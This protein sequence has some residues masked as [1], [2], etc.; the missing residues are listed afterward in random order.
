MAISIATEQNPRTSI[1][2]SGVGVMKM[3]NTVPTAGLKPTSL[4]LQASVLPLHH[5]GF[6]DVTTIPTPTYV[7]SLVV[8]TVFTTV[9][10][11]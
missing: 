11:I 3:G 10:I 9:A 6:P 8:S 7:C 2:N 4:S 1:F 5:V